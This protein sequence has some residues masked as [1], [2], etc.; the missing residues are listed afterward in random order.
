MDKQERILYVAEHSNLCTDDL[1]SIL[2][3]SRK[4]VQRDMKAAMSQYP[5][6]Y[7]TNETKPVRLDDMPALKKI[8]DNLEEVVQEDFSEDYLKFQAVLQMR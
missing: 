3:V 4:T 1:A 6:K 2:N 5:D 7:K 8:V